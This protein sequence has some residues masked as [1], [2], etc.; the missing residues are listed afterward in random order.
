MTSIEFLEKSNEKGEI[1]LDGDVTLTD[2][3]KI[4]GRITQLI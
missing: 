3:L 2:S 1:T 4:D